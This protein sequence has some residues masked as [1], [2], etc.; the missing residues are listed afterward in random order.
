MALGPGVPDPRPSIAKFQCSPILAIAVEN[1]TPS[2][3]IRSSADASRIL[4]RAR[5]CVTRF[6]RTTARAQISVP[7]C[8]R[9][10][11]YVLA[12]LQSDEVNVEAITPETTNPFGSNDHDFQ[13]PLSTRNLRGVRR[14]RMHFRASVR[15][16]P[17]EGR[18][19]V[20]RQPVG[21]G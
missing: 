18:C 3:P 6:L 17:A 10:Y 7:E 14:V 11:S 15:R 20:R 9:A 19:R 1:R 21:S 12:R 2:A 16:W 5:L 8:E 13:H 4:P